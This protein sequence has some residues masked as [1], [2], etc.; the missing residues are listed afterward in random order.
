MTFKNQKELFEWIWNNRPH[1]S[2]INGEPLHNPGH[3]LF[4]NQFSHIL[5]KS[6]YPA[7]KL[8][9]ENVILITPEQHD[10]W[11]SRPDKVRNLLEWQPIFEEYE[12]LKIKYHEGKFK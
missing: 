12:I 1:V 3:Y 5:P 9:E 10:L 11:G 8:Y 6:I 2:E 4:W 7:A